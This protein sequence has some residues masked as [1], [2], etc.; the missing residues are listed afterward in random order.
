M[1]HLDR[2]R[3]DIINEFYDNSVM[4]NVALNVES[5]LCD[6]VIL[7][8][9]KNWFKAELI[10][11][12]YIKRYTVD[13]IFRFDY[14]DMPDPEGALVLKRFGTIVEYKKIKE[15]V[16]DEEKSEKAGKKIYKKIPAWYVRLSIPRELVSDE[17]QREELDM[18]DQ[19]IDLEALENAANENVEDAMGGGDF[20]LGGDMGGSDMAAT[21][22]D[23]MMADT[24]P[25]DTEIQ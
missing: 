16:L 2:I 22:M 12:P 21:D 7:Y 11:G 19:L 25:E 24:G 10:S 15:P 13:V 5:F 17:K 1:R 23:A 8:P 4:L 18:L 20:G 14:E 6:E 9:Y 3:D